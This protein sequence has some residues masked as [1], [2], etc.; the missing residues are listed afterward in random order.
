MKDKLAGVNSIVEAIKGGRKIHKIYIQQGRSGKKIEELLNLAEKRGIYVQEVEKKRLDQMYTVSNH[1]GIIAQVDTYDYSELGE[2]LEYATLKGEKPFIIMLDGL[3]DP[4][5]LGSIIRTA[6][7]AGVHGIIIPRHNSV[8]ITAAV[9]KASAGAVEHIHIV[10]ETNLVN[11]LT[12]LKEQG[13]WIIGADMFAKEDYFNSDIPTPA[14]LVIGS[15][16]KGI[17]RLVKENCDVL[18]KIPMLG[19]INSLNASIAAALLMYEV[20]RQGT[21]N[22]L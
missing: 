10:R 21:R 3:E 1:Q 6:E 12:Y 7:C 8:E 13:M 14:V 15:E 4:Q 17:R 22:D 2:V 5:N 20:V 16:G 19:K 9:A 18:V 11:T